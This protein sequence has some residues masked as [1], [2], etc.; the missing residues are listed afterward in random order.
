MKQAFLI[1]SALLAGCATVDQIQGPHNEP[2][3]VISCPGTNI[4]GCYTKASEVCPSGYQT[5]AGEGRAPE[6][7]TPTG[8]PYMSVPAARQITI[9]CKKAN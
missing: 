8:S 1:L 2:A 6:A 9:Q 4:T 3:Y 5:L 7:M